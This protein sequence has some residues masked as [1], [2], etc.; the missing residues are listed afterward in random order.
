VLFILFFFFGMMFDIQQNK[1]L[2]FKIRR[3]WKILKIL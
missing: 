1:H 3:F 2:N